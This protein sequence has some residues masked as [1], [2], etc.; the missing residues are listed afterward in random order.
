[1]TL[2]LFKDEKIETHQNS[3]TF[4]RDVFGLRALLLVGALLFVSATYWMTT[5]G[6]IESADAELATLLRGM[7]ML[8]AGFAALAL[9]AVWWRLGRTITT[10]RLLAYASGAWLMTV[11]A[12]LIWQLAFIPAASALFHGGILLL[13]VLAWRDDWPRSIKGSRA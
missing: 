9:A 3:R 11:G 2:V 8:K 10:P 4:G 1:M 13:L 7:A 12:T 5:P 6:K